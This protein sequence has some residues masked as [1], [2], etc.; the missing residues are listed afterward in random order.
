MRAAASVSPRADPW[1][2]V[3]LGQ[4]NLAVRGLATKPRGWRE[5]KWGAEEGQD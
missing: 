1:E 4:E 3:Y 2:E 5:G